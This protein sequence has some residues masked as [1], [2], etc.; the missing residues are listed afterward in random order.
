MEGRLDE[1]EVNRF[2]KQAIEPCSIFSP[3]ILSGQRV[4]MLKKQADD[5]FKMQVHQSRGGIEDER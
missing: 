3:T 4:A 5:R 1:R 2:R